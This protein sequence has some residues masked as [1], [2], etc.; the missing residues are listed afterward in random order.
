MFS[1]GRSGVPAS[2]RRMRVCTRCRIAFLFLCVI[3]PC[4]FLKAE[5]PCGPVRCG[6]VAANHSQLLGSGLADLLLQA[7]IRV[8]HALV[9]V[10]IGLAQRA[11]VGR[12][13]TDLL[14]VNAADGH[15]CL[16][17]VDRRRDPCGQRKL[18]RV[19][20]AEREN[21]GVFTLQ[22][23]AVADAD[24]VQILRPALRYPF[25]GIRYQRARQTV[26]GSLRVVVAH[27][28]QMAFLLFD[29]D[30]IRNPLN[31]LALRSFD[32]HHIPLHRV[33][34]VAR[35]RN[36]LLSNSCHLSLPWWLASPGNVCRS[37]AASATCS[38][39]TYLTSY[40]PRRDPLAAHSS[41]D[42]AE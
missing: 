19:R 1:R 23:S 30:T 35:Q 37:T 38:A 4:S 10:R 28:V 12:D 15:P 13:L 33:L 9:L 5:P 6:A 18:D 34:H 22:F 20:V 26:N 16:L 29:P 2:R 17:R 27:R 25:D 8:T 32:G 21:D 42:F 40:A 31:H 24:N 11:H 41:P 14:A 7:L 3:I 39:G 36:R